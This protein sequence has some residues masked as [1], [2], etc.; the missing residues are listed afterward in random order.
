MKLIP[1]PAAIADATARDYPGGSFYVVDHGAR[2]E[3]VWSGDHA[4]RAHAA[5]ARGLAAVGIEAD[6]VPG[7]GVL[8]MKEATCTP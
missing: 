5:L 8:V 6:D 4:R 1:S 3:F 7:M 2:I